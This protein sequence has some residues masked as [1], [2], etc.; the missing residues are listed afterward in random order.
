M[1]LPVVAV[2]LVPGPNPYGLKIR[3]GVFLKRGIEIANYYRVFRQEVPHFD[4]VDHAI[5]K[6]IAINMVFVK[7]L[8]APVNTGRGQFAVNHLD[9]VALFPCRLARLRV[10]GINF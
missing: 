6:N 8:G 10:D 1:A 5:L 4:V 7:Q 9:G 3:R 2:G